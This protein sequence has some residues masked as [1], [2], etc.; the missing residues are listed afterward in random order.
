[1]KWV[2]IFF[3]PT[4]I[5]AHKDE[6]YETD[7]DGYKPEPVKVKH[8]DEKHETDEDG[9][10]VVSKKIPKET[11]ELI[12]SSYLK[13]V[14]PIFQ[15]KCLNCHGTGNPLPWYSTI[16]GPKQLILYDIKEAKEHMD[17][18]NDFPF[19]G[20]GTPSDDLKAL[21]ETVKEGSMP[22]FRYKIMHWRSSLNES[23]KKTINE[24]VEGSLK[25]INSK[26][27]ERK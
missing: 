22:P 4:I 24:W 14:K 15:K 1:M 11:M 10:E 27:E 13:N 17:M 18:T 5:L 26:K 20:H 25:L 16:P 23:D 19:S 3:L 6:K 12:N 7:K 9:W 21:A 2:L 8:K